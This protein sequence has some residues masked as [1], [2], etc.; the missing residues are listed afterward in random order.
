MSYVVQ[1]QNAT[2]VRDIVGC[3]NNAVLR[4]KEESHAHYGNDN[5]RHPTIFL[6]RHYSIEAL[7]ELTA[8][9]SPKQHPYVE[10]NY[11]KRQRVNLQ[12]ISFGY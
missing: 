11:T 5:S 1:L 7:A 2:T 8:S 3:G 6:Y 9:I 12:R 4:N 10:S